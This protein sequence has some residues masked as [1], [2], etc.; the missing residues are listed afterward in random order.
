MPYDS[1]CAYM[2]MFSV[3]RII[4]GIIHIRFSIEEN[5]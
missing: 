2:V 3:S 5:C 4:Y 1:K